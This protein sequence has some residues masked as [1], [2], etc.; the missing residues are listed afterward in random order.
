MI[1]V[2]SMHVWWWDRGGCPVSCS[3]SF[4]LIPLRQVSQQTWNQ[5]GSQQVPV[6]ASFFCPPQYRVT[7]P[8]VW[9]LLCFR[10]IWTQALTRVQPMRLPSPHFVSCFVLFEMRSHYVALADLEL[11]RQIRLAWNSQG[12]PASA[13]G[14]LECHSAGITLLLLIFFPDFPVKFFCEYQ[15]STYFVLFLPSLDHLAAPTAV[16]VSEVNKWRAMC[17]WTPVIP[18]FGRQS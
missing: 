4:C 15:P 11:V 9:L 8:H 10:R 3:V 16:C 12:Q 13:S 18:E 2:W 17:C 6:L 5:A 1:T 7:E 14:A